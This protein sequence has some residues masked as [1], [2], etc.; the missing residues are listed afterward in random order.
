MNLLTAATALGY[1]AGWV[2]GWMAYSP[3]VL[4]AFGSPED[5]IAGFIFVGTPSVPL[6]ERPRPAFE[7]VVLEWPRSQPPGDE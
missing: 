3:R 5:R 4:A 6:E 7:E 1:S 2:T